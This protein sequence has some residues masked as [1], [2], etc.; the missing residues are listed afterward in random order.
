MVDVNGAGEFKAL[1]NTFFEVAA[2]V[3]RR[4]DEDI[5]EMSCCPRSALAA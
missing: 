5:A 3:V 2:R 1:V 4:D